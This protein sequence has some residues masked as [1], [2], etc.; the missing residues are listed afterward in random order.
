MT[1]RGMSKQK[2]IVMSSGAGVGATAG[3][4]CQPHAPNF[5]GGTST[6]DDPRSD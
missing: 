2:V 3:G 1:V 6:L 5:S 4:R